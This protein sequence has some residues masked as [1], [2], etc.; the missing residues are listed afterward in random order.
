M[1]QAKPQR[2]SQQARALLQ[3]PGNQIFLSAAS[4]WEIALGKLPLPL[5]PEGLLPVTNMLH[6]EP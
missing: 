2:L 6:A 5:P 3:E 1:L 4:S